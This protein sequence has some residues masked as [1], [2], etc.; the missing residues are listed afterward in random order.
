[1]YNG[2]LPMTLKERRKEKKAD[3]FVGVIEV[4]LR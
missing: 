1:M 2:T 4:T 3:D